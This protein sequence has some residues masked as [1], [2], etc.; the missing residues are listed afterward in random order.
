M[1][2][3]ATQQ[4]MLRS[5]FAAIDARDTA[6]FLQHL[7]ASASFRFGSAPVVHGRSQIG[8]AVGGFFETIE[9]LRHDID[10]SI[11]DGDILV[12]EGNV[13]YKRHDG[14]SIALPYVDVFRLA[15]D[16]ISEYKIYMDI[17]PLYA[18]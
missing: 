16:L 10:L 14:S 13:T 11:A 3:S 15:G 2:I 12:C 5:L 9:S 1:S 4:S 8:E 17:N 18:E 6:G 7:D